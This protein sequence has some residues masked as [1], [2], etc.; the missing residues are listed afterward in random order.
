M[1]RSWDVTGDLE[2]VDV[3]DVFEPERL[4]LV[5]FLGALDTDAWSRATAC[6]GW[7]VHDVALHLLGND[8]G[9]LRGPNSRRSP[10]EDTTFDELAERIERSN[11]EWVRATRRIDPALV[12]EFLA[13]I[14]PRVAERFQALDPWQP[15]LSVA[16]TGT[17]PSPA[18]LDI[19][20]EYT[21]RWVHHAQIREAVDER[22]LL[23]RRWLYPVLDTFMRCLP[24]AYEDVEAA[25]GVRVALTVDGE[26][27]GRWVV[28]RGRERWELSAMTE[29]PFD[30]ELVVPDHIAWKLL[31]RLMP[32]EPGVDS[33]ESRGDAGLAA[34]ATRAVAVMTTK[35]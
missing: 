28:V 34:V 30:A 24:R 31:T 17:G 14:G 3:H 35:L 20:R 12:V 26:A 1:V 27:G 15:G 33:I 9:R 5:T 25:E 8:F 10:A 18:W 32:L 7:S 29:P 19:A 6:V 22:P 13:L 16:W 4:E 11:E 23:E 2:P 21:E